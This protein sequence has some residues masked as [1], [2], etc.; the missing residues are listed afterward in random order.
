MSIALLPR[1]R[2]RYLLLHARPVT[3]VDA[4]QPRSAALRDIAHAN[5]LAALECHGTPDYDNVTLHNITEAP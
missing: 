3:M 1:P 4:G 2:R 5:P